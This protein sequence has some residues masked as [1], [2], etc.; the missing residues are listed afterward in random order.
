MPEMVDDFYFK[1]CVFPNCFIFVIERNSLFLSNLREL[2]NLVENEAFQE[3][4]NRIGIITVGENINIYGINLHSD[5]T[6]ESII[7]KKEIVETVFY[8]QLP[9]ISPEYLFECKDAL[10]IFDYLQNSKITTFEY[11]INNILK[12]CLLNTYYAKG[13]KLFIILQKKFVLPENL[14][15]EYIE[16]FVENNVSLSIFSKEKCGLEEIVRKTNGNC[17]TN[18]NGFKHFLKTSY[19]GV[20]I[21]LRTSDFLKRENVYANTSI[22][23]TFL[24]KLPSMNSQSCVTYKLSVEEVAKNLEKVFVQA[25]IS[26]YNYLGEKK[27]IVFN[28]GLK[29]SFKILDIFS[30]ISFDTLFSGFVK[31]LYMENKCSAHLKKCIVKCL[32]F[33]RNNAVR[34]VSE[35]QMV[36][37]ETLK[38]FPLLLCCLEKN[39]LLID[40]LNVERNLRYFYPRLYS[41]TEYFLS[42]KIEL[43][44]L[45]LENIDADEIY[46]IE[47]GYSGIFYVG[48]NVEI[49]DE[50]FFNG[51][52]KEHVNE[53]INYISSEYDYDLDFK[54]IRQGKGDFEVLGMMVE[55]KMNTVASYSDYLCEMHFLVKEN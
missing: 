22:Q 24:V 10:L 42:K 38:L 51:E 7:Y 25:C 47:N 4:Y 8:S 20:E 53:L 55:D 37:P 13:T 11:D 5:D 39:G 27:T 44:N 14:I 16:I 46:F 17:I 6:E 12:L 41:F 43:K 29:V 32:K 2:K 31:M 9:F 35:S 36:L 1:K 15:S 48:K 52:L 18:Y 54:I 3:Q 45:F 21:S 33:Y 23:N 30:E 49:N 26:F 28:L 34:P 40:N 19:Y 50:D